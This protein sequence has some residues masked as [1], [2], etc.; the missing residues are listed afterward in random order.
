MIYW[1]L[2]TITYSGG[3]STTS[4]YTVVTGGNDC[5]LKLW[6]FYYNV[7]SGWWPTLVMRPPAIHMSITHSYA[8]THTPFPNQ[9]QTTIHPLI[10]LHPITHSQAILDYHTYTHTPSSKN[11]SP[12][13]PVTPPIHTLQCVKSRWTMNYV[14]T[15]LQLQAVSLV[16]IPDSSYRGWYLLSP[17]LFSNPLLS[18][19]LFSNPLP[20]LYSPL[21]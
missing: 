10:R 20:H 5:I 12:P 4:V 13:I 8:S 3:L 6:R 16:T 9:Y 21:F 11:H 19:H 18:P 17:H 1:S 15:T 14:V 7:N 2:L